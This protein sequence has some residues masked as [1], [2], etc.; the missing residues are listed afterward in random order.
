MFFG[1]LHLSNYSIDSNFYF[2]LFLGISLYLN[3]NVKISV[4]AHT[5][6]IILTK[7]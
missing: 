1:M 2:N 4:G 5:I 3:Y 6:T 7:L